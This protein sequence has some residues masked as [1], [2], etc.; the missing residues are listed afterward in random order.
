MAEAGSNWPVVC[1]ALGVLGFAILVTARS[2]LND[3]RNGHRNRREAMVAA[4]L[5]ELAL[6]VGA[7]CP[8]DPA[9][10]EVE[11]VRPPRGELPG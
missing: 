6:L 1:L 10:A 7:P 3:S 8:D 11:G 5:A 4:G 2:D 9:R